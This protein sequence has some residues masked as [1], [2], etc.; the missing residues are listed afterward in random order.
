MCNVIYKDIN[1]SLY[2]PHPKSKQSANSLFTFMTKIEYLKTILKHKIIYPRYC[3]EN[4]SYLNLNQI[5]GIAFPMKCYCDIYLNKLTFHTKTYGHYGIAFT[6]DWGIKNNIQPIHYINPHIESCYIK[7]IQSINNLRL[8]EEQ[9]NPFL[10]FE[11]NIHYQN[12]I[13]ILKLVKPLSGTMIRDGK[14]TEIL[15]FHDEHEWR[16]VPYIQHN[17]NIYPYL[18]DDKGLANESDLLSNYKEYG[19]NF[20]INDIKY[21]VLSSEKEK[22]LLGNFFKNECFYNEIER[23][24]LASKIIILEELEGDL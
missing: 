1:I 12:L 16:F 11:D 20:D 22:E 9:K 15:N 5:N 3:Y 17:K 8:L 13:N 4:L 6:K 19:L 14:E 24:M 23:F 21:I 2:V 10:K 18:L 7:T